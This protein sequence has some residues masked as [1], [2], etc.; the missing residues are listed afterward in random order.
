MVSWYQLEGQRFGKLTVLKRSGSDK[1]KKALWTCECDCGGETTVTTGQLK[2]GHTK[3]CGCGMSEWQKQFVDK[4]TK[5]GMDGT[6]E[7]MTWKRLFGRCYNENNQYYYLYGGK[8]IGV[9]DRWNPIK[10][11]YFEN[12][13]EDM[14]PR[15]PECTSIERIDGNKDYSPDNCRWADY[16][17]QSRNT[18]QNWKITINGETKII[19]DWA[20]ESPVTEGTIRYRIRNLGWSPEKA[21]YTKPKD[22][23]YRQPVKFYEYK[24]EYYSVPELC[25]MFNVGKTTF[26][27]N[28]SKG[29]SA[30]EIVE[31]YRRD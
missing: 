23:P 19:G 4:H 6:P 31:K 29:M 3:S 7:H 24:E 11:G 2:S 30:E 18:S 20:R 1:H 25:N 22:R 12:F 14:G 10:G 26:R 5:H 17:E 8:G 16:S 21:V 15:P 27:R 13:Y 9:C 28:L